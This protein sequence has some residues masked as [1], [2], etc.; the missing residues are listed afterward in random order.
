MAL[1]SNLGDSEKWLEEHLVLFVKQE[2]GECPKWTSPGSKG[3]HD[4]LVF[5]P[6]GILYIIELKSRGKPRQPLQEWWHRRLTE[7]GYLSW[8]IECKQDLEDFKEH[9]KRR[10]YFTKE[11]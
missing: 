6:K 7:L 11:S 5:L 8:K 10:L 4:R 9:A 3:V 2:K 1:N